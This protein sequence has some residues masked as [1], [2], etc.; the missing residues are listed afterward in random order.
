MVRFFLAFVLAAAAFAQSNFHLKNGDVVVFYGDSITDQRL[1]TTFAETYAVTRFPEQNVTFIHKGWGG[2]RVTGGGGGT[3]ET[4]LKRDVIPYKPTVITIMLGMN[5]GRY[6]A[7][8]QAIFEEYANGMRAIVS[9]LKQS[10]PNARITLIE[11]SPYDDVTRP[12]TFTG[13]YNAV[14]VRYGQF[15]RELAEKEHLGT[16]DLNTSVVASLQKAGESDSGLAQKISPDRVH[17][18]PGGHLLMAAAL[19]KAWN[20]PALVSSVE[21]DGAKGALV[22]AENSA[23][24]AVSRVSGGLSWTQLDRALPLPIN[25][26]DPVIALAVRSSDIERSLDWQPLKVTGLAPGHYALRIDGEPVG[27]FPADQLAAGINL[28][29]LPTP[30]AKQAADVHALTLKH[31]AVHFTR[32]RTVQVPLEGDQLTKARPA[33]EALDEVE[34]EIVARQHEVAKPKSRRFELVPEP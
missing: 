23:V 6:R 32:W 34:K 20:A 13:G 28:A 33:M 22:R 1:Y 8:D 31:N 30:M 26:K 2:D 18:G 4:R 12:P 15:L 5:D 19:L 17:P 11:P 10:L 24:S 9:T 16:A 7:F 14:L 27:S 21:L 25:M 3:I 29:M